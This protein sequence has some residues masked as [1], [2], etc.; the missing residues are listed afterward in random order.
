MPF[1]NKIGLFSSKLTSSLFREIL[2]NLNSF[3]TFSSVLIKIVESKKTLGIP[4]S[5]NFSLSSSD[6]SLK[7]S[8]LCGL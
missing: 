6:Q 2:V 1:K 8:L 7:I 3:F 4:I 5:N